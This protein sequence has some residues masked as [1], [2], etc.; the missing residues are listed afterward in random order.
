[1]PLAEPQRHLLEFRKEEVDYVD[2]R[3][4]FLA[5]EHAIAAWKIWKVDSERD[6][7]RLLHT[8]H[9][10]DGLSACQHTYPC[11]SQLI[12]YHGHSVL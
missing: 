8:A 7:M 10:F 1:M 4:L 5:E 9:L 3:K 11:V 6:M 12:L 2:P